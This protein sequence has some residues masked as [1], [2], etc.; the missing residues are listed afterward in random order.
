MITFSRITKGTWRVI[1]NNVPIPGYINR[2]KEKWNVRLR[3]EWYYGYDSRQTAAKFLVRK[4]N[5]DT[6]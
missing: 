4:Y 6:K 3:G 2:V 1:V 5:K